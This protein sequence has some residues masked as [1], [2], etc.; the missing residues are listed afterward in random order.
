MYF[1]E[2]GRRMNKSALIADITPLPQGYSGK[3]KVRKAQSHIAGD[4]AI[5]SYDVD[6][7]EMIF[8]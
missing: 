2:K 1:D 4:T 7:S 3:I 8:G 6:E 5:L